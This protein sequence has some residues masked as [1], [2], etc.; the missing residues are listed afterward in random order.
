VLELVRADRFEGLPDRSAETVTG[1]GGLA[2]RMSMVMASGHGA[3]AAAIFSATMG[4]ASEA[5]PVL[6]LIR[7]AVS[8]AGACSTGGYR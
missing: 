3:C 4:P 6:L 5:L 8:S 7:R 1:P 2:P